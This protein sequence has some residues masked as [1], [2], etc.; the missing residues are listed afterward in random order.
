MNID[1]QK[2]Y[3]SKNERYIER[4]ND[5]I[6][7]YNN[8]QSITNNILAGIAAPVMQAYV[9]NDGSY[10]NFSIIESLLLVGVD[11]N[12][13]KKPNKL[14]HDIFIFQINKKSDAVAAATSKPQNL[15]EEEIEQGDYEHEY[16]KER[17]GNPCNLTS[18][19]KGNGIG[20]AY[21]S[22]KDKCPYDN[23]KRYF[24]CLP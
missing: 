1:G 24:E 9:M 14:G 8:K 13:A 21:Y 6:R 11:T 16:Q 5:N 7:T 12:G 15:S 4:F 18:N 22:L 19:Q 17:A 20:C 23:S 3:T 10:I 2:H